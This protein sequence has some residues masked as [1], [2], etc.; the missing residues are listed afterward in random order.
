MASIEIPTDETFFIEFRTKGNTKFAP[1]GIFGPE[2]AIKLLF[3]GK[4]TRNSQPSVYT[5]WGYLYF[6][7]IGNKEYRITSSSYQLTET[8]LSA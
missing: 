3:A 7:E 8:Y 5:H 1:L 6:V 2:E 4:V